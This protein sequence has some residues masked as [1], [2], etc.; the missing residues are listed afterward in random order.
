MANKPVKKKNITECSKNAHIFTVTPP[1]FVT[2]S[3][4]YASIWRPP[5]N[6]G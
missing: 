6:Y 1:Y 2:E 5:D 3:N 4:A